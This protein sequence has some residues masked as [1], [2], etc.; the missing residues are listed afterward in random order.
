MSMGNGQVIWIHEM[1]PQPISLVKYIID[2]SQDGFQ[3]SSVFISMLIHTPDYKNLPYL[4]HFRVEGQCSQ[5]KFSV[6]WCSRLNTKSVLINCQLLVQK[7]LQ[8]L[9]WAGY[10][11]FAEFWY[12]IKTGLQ[13]EHFSD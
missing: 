4:V 6:D 9:L 1:E 7:Y 8:T 11:R 10:I 2:A 5:I 13:G 12:H 3:S